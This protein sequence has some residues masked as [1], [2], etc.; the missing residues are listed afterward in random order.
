M[1]AAWSGV[2]WLGHDSFRFDGPPVVYLD[3]FE[4][5]SATPAAD[6]VL[7]THEHFDHCSPEDLARCRTPAT[8]VVAPAAAAALLPGPVT[9][10]S[11][12]QVLRVGGVFL[13][14]VPA[15]NTERR[16]HPRKAG[17]L[18]Y[19]VEIGTT[20]VYHAGD[21]DHIP[22]MT[23]LR[24]DLALLPVSGTY[25]MTAEEAAAAAKSL[26]ALAVAPMHWGSIVGGRADADRLAHLLRGSG[27]EVRIL[28]RE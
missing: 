18:G 27:I 17:G 5:P 1:A 6:M 3:P 24:P 14:A 16:F 9:V 25:V 2:H 12:G 4:L 7:I 26:G 11:A 22:E 20:L 28:E 10:I 19:L 23:G 15:Y 8:V 21:T 13:R